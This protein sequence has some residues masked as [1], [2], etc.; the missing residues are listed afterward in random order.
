MIK[1]LKKRG[2]GVVDIA[3]EKEN[4]LAALID[5]A[6]KDVVLNDDDDADSILFF[7]TKE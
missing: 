2:G 5:Q 6:G 7:D 1:P 3:D 4:E